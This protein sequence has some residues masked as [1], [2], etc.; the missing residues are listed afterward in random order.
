MFT[1]PDIT[2][3]LIDYNALGFDSILGAASHIVYILIFVFLAGVSMQLIE[4]HGRPPV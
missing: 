2:E 3:T 4:P 1:G